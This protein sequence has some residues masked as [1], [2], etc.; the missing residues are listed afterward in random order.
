MRWNDRGAI[1]IHVAIALIALITFTSIVVDYGVMWVSR[2]QAQAAAD[3]GALAGALSLLY[4][5]SATTQATAAAQHFA[6]ENVVWGEATANTD[7]VVSPLPFNCPDGVPSCIRVDVMRGQPDRDGGAHSNTLPTYFAKM[8]GVN[9]QGVRATATAQVAAGNAVQ[10]IKPWVVSDKWT[11]NSPGGLVS[12]AW[13]QSDTF[14]P[15]VDTYTARGFSA[16]TDVGLE[17]MLKGEGHDWSSGWTLEIELG[18][19]NGGNVYNDEIRGCPP[20]VKTIGLWQ[21][22]TPCN[23]VPDQDEEKGCL[24]VKTGVKQGPTIDGVHYLVSLDPGASWDTTN[25]RVTGGCTSAGTCSTAN[26]LGVGIS[27]RIVPL[28]LFDPGSYA[29][30]GCS[31]NNCMARVMNLL[32]FFVEGMCDEVFVTPPV[33]CGTGSE[34][35]KTVVG[36]LMAYPGQARSAS[37]SAG[38]ETFL[39]IT[40]LIR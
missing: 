11:D 14:D 33:W 18:G 35:S 28:A 39:K 40:R 37:G 23:G 29:A 3:A 4:D 26:P 25:S 38:P 31:G 21:S 8:A 36:R 17:L 7:I 27:P 12:G 24:N 16:A 15:A 2:T 19:G 22:P 6:S 9:S 30:L 34:P 1:T 10:C 32:G 13:D 5:P 20:W